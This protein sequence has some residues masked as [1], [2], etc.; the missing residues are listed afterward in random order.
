MSGL[1]DQ[2]LVTLLDPLG[3][4]PLKINGQAVRVSPLDHAMTVRL[5]LPARYADVTIEEM[6]MVARSF[7]HLLQQLENGRD[8]LFRETLDHIARHDRHPLD[9]MKSVEDAARLLLE[10]LDINLDEIRMP[11][12]VSNRVLNAAWTLRELLKQKPGAVTWSRWGYGDQT[13][14][15]P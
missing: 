9:R 15:M 3:V 8:Q 12:G 7:D 14:A 5:A 11:H 2:T 13:A 4:R 1:D 6:T 10:A